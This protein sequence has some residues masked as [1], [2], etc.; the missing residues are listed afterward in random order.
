MRRTSEY[1]PHVSMCREERTKAWQHFRQHG[2]TEERHAVALAE[3][4]FS[5]TAI[6]SLCHVREHVAVM[7]V[8][9]MRK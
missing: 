8:L 6:T 1:D 9:G 2:S 7:V 3:Q 5:V 4:G